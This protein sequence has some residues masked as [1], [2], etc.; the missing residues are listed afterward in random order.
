MGMN[1]RE[2]AAIERMSEVS[3]REETAE[4]MMEVKDS[5]SEEDEVRL[6]YILN[7]CD[8]VQ[9]RVVEIVKM[10]FDNIAIEKVERMKKWDYCSTLQKG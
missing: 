9:E 7:A 2:T 8:Q 3:K 5:T 1:D 10:M 4:T 6:G